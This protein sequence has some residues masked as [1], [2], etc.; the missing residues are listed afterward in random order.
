[1]PHDH[2]HPHV[3]VVARPTGTGVRPTAV[4]GELEAGDYELYEKLGGPIALTVAVRG[5][6]VTEARW[7]AS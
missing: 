2:A 6:E 3:A 5:G 1:M 4:F 7:P